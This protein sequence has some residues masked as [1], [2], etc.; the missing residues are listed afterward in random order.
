MPINAAYPIR[1]VAP[2]FNIIWCIPNTETYLTLSFGSPIGSE[3]IINTLSGASRAVA[4]RIAAQ[5]DGM[6]QDGM[7]TWFQR[8]DSHVM[9]R[10][11]NA[12]NH[13]IT[14][15]VLASALTG[16]QSYMRNVAY[17]GVRFKLYDG[18]NQVGQGFIEYNN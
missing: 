16:L 6:L 5:G 15:G 8:G 14:Y 9:L 13:Q 18:K 4:G 11:L 10:V 12:N 1:P 2:N 17:G 7:F 3:T